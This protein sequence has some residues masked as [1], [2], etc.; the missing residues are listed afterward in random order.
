[1]RQGGR[2]SKGDFSNAIS[3]D[4]SDLF[5]P[6]SNITLTS[7]DQARALCQALD[8][9]DLSKQWRS[10]FGG[11]WLQGWHMTL[12]Q[13][14]G[15]PNERSCAFPP[16]DCHMLASSGHT[17]GVNLLL[18]DGSVRFVANNVALTAWRALGTRN[19]SE[20]LGGDY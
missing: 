14:T 2:Q 17:N 12:Y 20:P 18:T 4:R 3:T 8:P 11:Y 19:G 10:D 9:S 15:L 7:P 5:S 1:M 16:P 6:G 13:H